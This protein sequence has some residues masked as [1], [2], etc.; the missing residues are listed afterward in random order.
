MINPKL[1]L[2]LLIIIVFLA[3]TAI[4]NAFGMYESITKQNFPEALNSACSVL[5][6]AIPV[7][8]LVKLKR[9]A[10]MLELILSALLVILGLILLSSYSI[11]IGSFITITHGLIAGYLLTSECKRA[12]GLIS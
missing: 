12:F 1:T 4:G 3:L 8:G 9:W 5:I 2:R 11:V 7:Y 6:Y 10:R